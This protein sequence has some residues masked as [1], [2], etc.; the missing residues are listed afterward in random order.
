VARIAPL[1]PGEPIVEL[2][3]SRAGALEALARMKE[4][5]GTGVEG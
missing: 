1:A 2:G 4:S 5:R 3:P